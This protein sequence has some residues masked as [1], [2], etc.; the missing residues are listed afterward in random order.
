MAFPFVAVTS[1]TDIPIL[2][3]QDLSPSFPPCLPPP[4][5]PAE[6]FATDMLDVPMILNALV[7][8]LGSFMNFED[9]PPVDSKPIADSYY[10]RVIEIDEII[11][12]LRR[13]IILVPG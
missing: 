7:V 1:D 6:I 5:L 12:G 13:F 9:Q 10:F 2:G 3:I 11:G 8:C 4:S